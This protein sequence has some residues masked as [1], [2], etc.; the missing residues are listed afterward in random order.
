MQAN[1]KKCLGIPI[2]KIKVVF[3]YKQTYLESFFCLN[4]I[5]AYV[6]LAIWSEL[7]MHI[8]I[9][10][11][12]MPTC[13]AAEVSISDV[14]C[15][16]D[17]VLSCSVVSIFDIFRFT[18]AMF[19]LSSK[20][21]VKNVRQKCA[22]ITNCYHRM[23]LVC[24]LRYRLFSKLFQTRHS[25]FL[26]RPFSWSG[27]IFSIL[28]VSLLIERDIFFSCWRKDFCC[29]CCF[30]LHFAISCSISFWRV[31]TCFTSSWRAVNV[32]SCTKGWSYWGEKLKR[33]RRHITF[34]F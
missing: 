21:E 24:T 29:P 15:W 4:K 22:S 5:A 20:W 23:I 8:R 31:T 33:V 19:L 26:N 9:C 6:N 17:S 1:K 14:N 2:T 3:S 11:N 25:P 16:I 30:G 7:L 28:A 32:S 10:R 12:L 18:L 13:F 27:R 34:H